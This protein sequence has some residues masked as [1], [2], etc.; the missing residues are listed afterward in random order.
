[1]YSL[2]LNLLLRPATPPPNIDIN[3]VVT[4]AEM[5]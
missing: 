5:Q 4:E 3:D 1:M 2:E